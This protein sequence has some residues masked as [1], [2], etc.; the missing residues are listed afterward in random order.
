MKRYVCDSCQ[1]IINNPYEVR[2]KE[3][4]ISTEYDYGMVFPVPTKTKRR[5]HLCDDCFN[6][7]KHMGKTEE[8]AEE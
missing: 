2:M 1:K 4:F 3:F 5:I 6:A 7:L 8:G